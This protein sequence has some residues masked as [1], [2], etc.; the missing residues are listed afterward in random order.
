MPSHFAKV[1]CA[2][3][4]AVGTDDE[5]TEGSQWLGCWIYSDLPRTL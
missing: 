2:M 3:L 4:K 5:T 1:A